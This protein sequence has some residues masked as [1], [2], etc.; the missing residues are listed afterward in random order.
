MAET[1]FI[2]GP[3]TARDY[4]DALGCFGTGVT[5]VTTMTARGPLAITV[6][7]F[8][9]V[10][11]DPPLLLWCPAKASL[12]H[13]AF[14]MAENFAIHVMAED[15]LGLA[16]HFA[17]HGEDFSAA[18]WQLNDQGAPALD[19]VIARFDCR[20]FAAHLAGD[21]TIIIGEA[22]SVTTRPGK[23]LIF[24]RGQYGGFL[25]QS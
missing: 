20:R 17:A 7:S 25:E 11:L 15:Q 21:H 10:S 6:N 4:R 14:V 2:P 5:V 23:G 18:A 16:K 3:E 8:T 1:S 22:A 19:G 24:K 13:D 9:S 12:R